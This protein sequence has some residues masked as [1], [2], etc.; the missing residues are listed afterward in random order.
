[1][2]YPNNTAIRDNLGNLVYAV[3][4]PQYLG[5]VVV[6]SSNRP[7]RV[8]FTNYLPDTANGGNLFIPVD[9]TVMGAGAGPNGGT[10]SQNRATM[11]L[12]GGNTPWISDGTAHQWVT[13]ASENTQY[14]KGVSV[15]YVPDMNGGT[16]PKGTLSF[17]YTN[18]QSARL[19]FYH[20]H[21]LGITRLNVMVGEAAGYIV[22]DAAEQN[23][24]NGGYIPK[25][26][27]EIPLIIQDRTFVPNITQLAI[28]DPTWNWGSGSADTANGTG[29]VWMPHVYMPNQN[30]YD[31]TGANPMGRWDYGPWF[32]PPVLG[33]T[34]GP[35]ANPYAVNGP[36][37][38]PVEPGTPNPS[39]VPESFLDTPLVN[40]NPYP[41]VQV[42]PHAYRFR[43]LN[44]ANDRYLNL[45]L[46][47]A[48]PL[49]VLIT[50]GGFGYDSSPNVTFIGGGGTGAIAQAVLT[51]TT[52]SGINLTNGGTGYTTATVLF[53][54]GGGNGAAADS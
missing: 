29:D 14:P 24:I 13:P 1:M 41:T 42:G 28:T 25:G 4:R 26:A 8:K 40:G 12:H 21:A 17:Y 45:Q 49:S 16:E 36:W 50:R 20:D 33:L 18:Q 7:T 30:P 10:F 27:D 9:T 47:Y 2:F 22:R 32:W 48:E 3:E 52:V 53:S 19:M 34:H 23:L 39:Q 54:G 43:I 31:P 11:H 44:A 51:P 15:A 35:L 6:A 37:E 38:P 46:Y 5:P